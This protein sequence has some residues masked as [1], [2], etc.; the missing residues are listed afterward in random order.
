MQLTKTIHVLA[1]SLWFG[2]S[3]FFTFIAALVIFNT[4]GA[5]IENGHPDRP[6]WFPPDLQKE[7]GV[8]LGGLAVGPI[9]RWYFLL[10]G[11]CGVLALGTAAAWPKLEAQ[12]RLHR[13]RFIVL[14]LALGTVVAGWPL[15][16]KVSALRAARYAADSLIAAQAREAFG[17]WHTY[18][19]LLNIVTIILVGVAVAMTARLPQSRTAAQNQP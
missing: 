13:T 5:V 6:A 15:V 4:F 7:Q 12:A 16:E 3:V 1:L 18:S 8:Q 9:F 11:V 17:R 19:L 2:S 10:Q 14:A